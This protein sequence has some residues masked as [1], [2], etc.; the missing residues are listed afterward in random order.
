MARL[1]PPRRL[2]CLKLGRW[3]ARPLPT[4]RWRIVAQVEEADL[5]PD[6]LPRRGA[7]LVGPP[8]APKWLALDCPCGTGHRLLVNLDSR[9]RPTWRLVGARPLT[10]RPSLDVTRDGTRCHFTITC[11]TV[12]WAVSGHRPQMTFWR[13]LSRK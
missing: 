7:V 13:D 6:R 9:R 3:L 5:V 2:G 11:G 10:I 12:R 1:N 8:G 4:R